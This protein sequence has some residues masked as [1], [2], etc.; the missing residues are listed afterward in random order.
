MQIL[1]YGFA[2]A[3]VV[4]TVQNPTSDIRQRTI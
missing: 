2:D 1:K 4:G 3:F